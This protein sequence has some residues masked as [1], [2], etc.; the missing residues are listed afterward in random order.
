M[1]R[2]SYVLSLVLS[3]LKLI[4]SMMDYI[5]FFL[6]IF[7]ALEIWL[8][9]TIYRIKHHVL[10]FACCI[11]LLHLLIQTQSNDLSDVGDFMLMTILTPTKDDQIEL[12][13]NLVKNTKW[14]V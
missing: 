3:F 13:L 8:K 12:N 2:T 11:K 9:S 10:Q 7:M 6:I 4:E 1:S 14:K 5:N